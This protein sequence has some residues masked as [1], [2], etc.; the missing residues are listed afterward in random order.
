M[1]KVLGQQVARKLGRFPDDKAVGRLC[2]VCWLSADAYLW[3]SAP[4]DMMG[5][6]LG[7]STNSYL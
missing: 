4:H 7:S 2:G 1:L 5:S 3:P 6:V